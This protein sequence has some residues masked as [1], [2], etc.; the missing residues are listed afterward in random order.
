MARYAAPAW[1]G[2]PIEIVTKVGDT[3]TTTDLTVQYSL[4]WLQ[5]RFGGATLDSKCQGVA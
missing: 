4:D 5:N 1:P 2:A 3:Q